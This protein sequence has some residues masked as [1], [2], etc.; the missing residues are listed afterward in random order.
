VRI[1]VDMSALV[2]PGAHRGLG[3]Y[4]RAL[5]AAVSQLPGV[6]IVE[7]VGMHRRGRYDDWLGLPRRTWFLATHGPL[8]HATSPYQLVPTHVRSTA[9]SIQDAIPLDVPA[10]RQTGI[11]A[12]FFYG[13]ARRCSVVLTNSSHGAE[14]VHELIGVPRGRIVTATLPPSA[15]IGTASPACS[16][17]G[18]PE[19]LGD[20]ATSLIDMTAHDPRK[21][22]PWVLGAAARLEG[23]GV[24]VVLTGNGTER[25]VERNV[26]GTGRL[27]DRHICELFAGALCYVS[28]TAYEG[29]GLPPQEALALGTPVVAFKNTSLP[30]MLGPGAFW[31]DEPNGSWRHL[32][33]VDARDGA[34]L[35]LADAVLA[36]CEDSRLRDGLAVAG[37]NHVAQFTRERFAE[38][39]RAAYTLLGC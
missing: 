25:L 14:R 19:D 3:R 31:L 11:K 13:L 1:V 33:K 8:F 34:S 22:L 9:V 21:R 10:Y 32:G 2:Q 23:K 7:Y 36:V 20:Y 28:A 4:S 16:C 35:A 18:L 17:S 30:E 26:V 24:A 12:D 37:R 15:T 5:R 27:C 39:I 6:D 38:G 29:Q